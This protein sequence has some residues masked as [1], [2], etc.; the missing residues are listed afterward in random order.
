MKTT[1]LICVILLA[2]YTRVF[3]QGPPGPGLN[4]PAVWGFRYTMEEPF[5]NGVSVYQRNNPNY[6]PPVFFDNFPV[7]RWARIYPLGARQWNIVEGQ[8]IKYYQDI[9]LC[10]SSCQFKYMRNCHDFAWAPYM[11]DT[12]N[13]PQYYY[14]QDEAW[15]MDEGTN[16]ADYM[17]NPNLNWDDQSMKSLIT[18]MAKDDSINAG[19]ADYLFK[20]SDLEGL[21]GTYV[22]DEETGFQVG[23]FL[24]PTDLV[25]W[26]QPI[27]PL[28]TCDL[29]TIGPCTFPQH[30]ALLVGWIPVPYYDSSNNQYAAGVYVSKWGNSGLYF[31]RWGPFLINKSYCDTQHLQIFVPDLGWGIFNGEGSGGYNIV[32]TAW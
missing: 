21:R 12:L 7:A 22:N 17:T 3:S 11:L 25:N 10:Y 14:D 20:L 8:D 31:H 9:G 26:I 16:C 23:Q 13:S 15:W 30:S 1:F 6:V 2:D 29:D 4:A 27:I 18:S 19:Y 5:V 24:F 32:V 28:P